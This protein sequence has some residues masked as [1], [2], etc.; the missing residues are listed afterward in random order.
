MTVTAHLVHGLQVATAYCRFIE[1][2]VL[3]GTGV[4]AATFW[5]G[6]DAV[7]ADL[8]PKNAA[9]LAERDRLQTELDTWHQGPPGL[10]ADMAGYLHSSKP[11][12]TS[13]PAAQADCAD[14]HRQRGR[15]S[16]PAG[17]PAA[18]GAHPERALRPERRQRPL[19]SAC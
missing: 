3:P 9:L 1:D 8:A 5:Q 16:W 11:S 12:A 4:D 19:G 15:R 2:Q 7:V 13:M 6:F 17:R 18:G 14:H 10:I